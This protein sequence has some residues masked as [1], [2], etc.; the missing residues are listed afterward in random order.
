MNNVSLQWSRDFK[1]IGLFNNDMLITGYVD[2][3]IINASDETLGDFLSY[4]SLPMAQHRTKTIENHGADWEVWSDD[5]V[6]WGSSI[7]VNED[8]E[9]SDAASRA[10]LFIQA[11]IKTQNLPIL[12]KRDGKDWSVSVNT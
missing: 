4:M 6:T 12:L 3:D 11:E 5:A 9:D 7:S 8:I 1:Y 10:E 2:P